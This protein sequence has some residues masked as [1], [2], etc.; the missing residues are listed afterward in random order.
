MILFDLV[1]ALLFLGGVAIISFE[2]YVFSF[3]YTAA[4]I[5]AGWFLV[6]PFKEFVLGGW[7]PLTFKW[8]PLYI[9][10]GVGVAL[11]KWFFLI[12]KRQRKIKEVRGKFDIF[13]LDEAD[14]R[15]Q[16]ELKQAE[17]DAVERASRDA[18]RARNEN[19][20]NIFDRAAEL[21]VVAPPAVVQTSEQKAEAKALADA[22]RRQK[23]IKFFNDAIKSSEYRP[24]PIS[25]AGITPRQWRD[26][27]TVTH[28]LTPSAK[29]HLDDITAWIVEWPFVIVATVIQDLVV[30]F[31]R[32]VTEFFDWAFTQASRF[33]IRKAIGDL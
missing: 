15:R 21:V 2:K 17:K 27:E 29:D 33:W 24:D 26:S 14:A 13:L 3:F 10:I 32:R 12:L 4:L 1:L 11:V 20:A 23:F 22:E 7:K 28:L 18:R 5:A 19:S 31:A 9:G 8:L 16:A 30:E 6:S 25:T